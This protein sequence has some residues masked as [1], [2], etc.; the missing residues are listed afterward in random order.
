[1]NNLFFGHLF[2][3]KSLD[4]VTLKQDQLRQIEHLAFSIPQ[5]RKDLILST[6]ETFPSA[7]IYSCENRGRDMYP[8]LNAMR[9][10]KFSEDSIIVKW[11]DKKRNHINGK[12][13]SLSERINLLEY[14]IPNRRSDVSPLAKFMLLNSEIS[15]TTIDG[16][17]LPLALRIGSNKFQISQWALQENWNWDSIYNDSFFPAGGVFAIKASALTSSKWYKSEHIN[18]EYSYGGIDGTWAHA[19]ERWIGVLAGRKGYLATIK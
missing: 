6:L 19:S 8:F 5:Y 3:D 13:L 7:K 15:L 2:D 9:K 1:M 12:P 17:L 18:I 4:L 11:H 16:W 10:S 14:C